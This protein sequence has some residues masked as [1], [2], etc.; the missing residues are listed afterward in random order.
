MTRDRE[1]NSKKQPPAWLLNERPVEEQLWLKNLA[2]TTCIEGVTIADATKPD[3][4]LIY[5]NSGFEKLTGYSAAETCGTNC[6][7]LQ[8]KDTGQDAI[9]EIRRA[10]KEKRACVVEILNYRKDGKPFW[11]RLSI[12]PIRDHKGRV[13]H[14]MGIQSDV[15]ERRSSEE[16]LRISN[17]SLKK[18]NS[19]IKEDL[20]SAAKVQTSILPPRVLELSGVDASWHLVPSEELAGDTLNA[21]RLNDRY[22]VFYVLDVSGHGVQAALLSFTVNHWLAP[23]TGPD[24]ETGRVT[25]ESEF[26]T[27]CSPV[28][29]LQQL[30]RKFP[31]DPVIGQY[32]TLI[33]GV[34][35]HQTNEFRFVAAGH[36]SP[37]YLPR[38]GKPRILQSENFPVGVVADAAFK[39]TAI[40]MKPGDRIF[41]YSDGLLDVTNTEGER[42]EA[43]RLLKE[44]STLS[45][46]SLKS[47]LPILIDRLR[48]WSGKN[49]FDDD[50]SI[51]GF[52]IK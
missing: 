2:L 52:E 25:A 32:F 51:L 10:M 6:R 9:E 8:G 36:P 42:F 21:Y 50:I 12:T 7:F 29:V 13:S 11:N 49:S 30:N 48:E 24:G 41:L 27:L 19:I 47:G 23:A 46:G 3:C 33:Y 39:E 38:G 43:E 17:A 20:E 1:N 14:F 44:V 37:M 34:L 35:D 31:F 4:P 5:V 15:T 16:A 45:S 22:S 40:E 28:K 26:P 18:A